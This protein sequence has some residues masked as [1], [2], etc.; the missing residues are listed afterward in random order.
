MCVTRAT[1]WRR[2]RECSTIAVDVELVCAIAVVAGAAPS[3]VVWPARGVGQRRCPCG[4]NQRDVN[5]HTLLF[6]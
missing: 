6:F 1:A 2:R 3:S 4:V 5:L